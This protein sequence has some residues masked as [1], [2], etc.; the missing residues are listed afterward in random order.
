MLCGFNFGG[1]ELLLVVVVFFE[2]VC[3]FG[4]VGI[5]GLVCDYVVVLY[6]C[7]GV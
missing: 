5:E 3:F 2:F 4:K 1:Y 7:F 6:Y